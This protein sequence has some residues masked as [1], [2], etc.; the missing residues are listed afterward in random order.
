MM[1]CFTI[2]VNYT[3]KCHPTERGGTRWTVGKKF[4]SMV[5][6]APT[7][8]TLMK[9]SPKSPP[10]PPW[11]QG[12]LSGLSASLKTELFPL[13]SD[14]NP[15]PKPPSSCRVVLL[16]F[17]GHQLA[18][19]RPPS[20]RCKG[21][22]LFEPIKHVPAFFFG[23]PRTRAR[24]SG[25]S[26]SARVWQ[27]HQP[28]FCFALADLRFSPVA[29]SL[30]VLGQTFPCFFSFFLIYFLFSVHKRRLLCECDGDPGSKA[31]HIKRIDIKRHVSDETKKSER[32]NSRR[33]TCT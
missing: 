13:S 23:V 11:S 5:K 19:P 16:Q 31:R 25:C 10:S 33:I 21:P 32:T 9:P 17:M 4:S 3:A 30:P 24:A 2:T 1:D 27:A 8:F 22:G 14:A 20:S 12:S 26:A 18:K 7:N 29:L 28:G 6:Q 15:S